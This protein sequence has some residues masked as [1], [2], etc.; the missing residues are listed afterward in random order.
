MITAPPT[1][2]DDLLSFLGAKIKRGLKRFAKITKRRRKP[3][4]KV[5]KSPPRKKRK[6]L[7]PG[8]KAGNVVKFPRRA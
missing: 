3:V 5:R 1:M 8:A 4:R 2:L 6:A 7:G